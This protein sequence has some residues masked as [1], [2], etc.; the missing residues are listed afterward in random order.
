MLKS[1]KGDMILSLI[2]AVALWMYIVGEM[3][4]TT[5]KTY[6]EIP[7]TL[8]NEQTLT[9]NGLAVLTSS[10][11]DMTVTI[12][13]KRSAVSKVKSTDIVATVDLSNAAEGENQLAININVPSNVEVKSQ[14]IS[15]ITVK[16]EKRTSES[17]EVKVIYTGDK[18]KGEEPT[19]KKISPSKVTVSGAA[20]LVNKVSY[21]KASVN[22]DTVKS[23][24]SSASSKLT[25]MDKNDNEVDNVTLSTNKAKITSIMYDT[26][27]V[28][29]NV[30]I[31][32]D[33]D[34]YDRTTKVP[35][36]I[37]IK[38]ASS[39]L[40]KVS[41]ITAKTLDISNITTST[42]LNVTPVL[43]DGIEAADVS[44]D[45]TVKV[46][47]KN[48][49]QTKTFSF[50]GSSVDLTDLDSSLNG[51]VKTG[52]IKVT[53][54]ASKTKLANISKSDISLSAS[55]SGLTSGTHTVDLKA[56]CSKSYTKIDTSP[57]SIS[58]KIE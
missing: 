34:D 36:S 33:N 47:V 7:V 30:P 16:V 49:T 5:T 8:T 28:D 3:N 29:L 32:N 27:T 1:K 12:T 10:D 17:K 56:E 52:T 23:T 48:A 46:T 2:L 18:A 31:T 51:T 21:V 35:D 40:A 53:I 20:D 25:A 24:L 58:V 43:P 15:K 42:S 44:K 6:R 37:T 39:D 13:G 55:C 41:S 9:D 26:K 50:S 19:T 38:G 11:S 22:V 54:T 14:S 45:L 57:S 4:P